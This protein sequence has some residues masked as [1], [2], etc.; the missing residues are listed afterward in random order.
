MVG[1]VAQDEHPRQHPHWTRRRRYWRLTESAVAK[2]RDGISVMNNDELS[3]RQ[4]G[5]AHCTQFVESRMRVGMQRRSGK[6]LKEARRQP[7]HE[8]TLDH[9]HPLRDTLIRTRGRSRRRSPIT[10][11]KDNALGIVDRILG[12]VVPGYGVVALL[13]PHSASADKSAGPCHADQRERS[14]ALDLVY[15]LRTPSVLELFR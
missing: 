7:F 12:V 2:D 13:D 15:L 11:T 8:I 14:Q 4:L 10:W 1:S 6:V 3:S 9:G 5:Q